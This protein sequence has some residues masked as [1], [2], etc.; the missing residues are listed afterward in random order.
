LQISG[1]AKNPP[2]RK[3]QIN[4]G[5]GKERHQQT[6]AASKYHRTDIKERE[7]T[8]LGARIGRH[9]IHHDDIYILNRPIPQWWWRRQQ[10]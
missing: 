1:I 7:T 9:E 4:H 6:S 2:C 10:R 5:Q 8:R 3:Q